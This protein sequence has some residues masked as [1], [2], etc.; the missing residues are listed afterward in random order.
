[1]LH[2]ALGKLYRW[3]TF[4]LGCALLAGTLQCCG[5]VTQGEGGG[6]ELSLALP[7]GEDPALF[8]Y[9]VSTRS[10]KVTPDSGDSREFPWQEGGRVEV[11]LQKGDQLEFS[12]KDD[13]GRLLV[14]GQARVSGEKKDT[15]PVRRVL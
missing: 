3:F 11:D 7:S 5:S 6:L 2:S 4:F 9:G 1:M 8:W 10:L 12:G 15:I 13:Q 14:S